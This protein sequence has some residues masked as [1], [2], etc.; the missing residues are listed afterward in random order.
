MRILPIFL[1]LFV[2]LIAIIAVPIAIHAPQH[3]APGLGP[4]LANLGK[5]E[6]TFHN[7]DLQLAGLV[8]NPDR[9][10]K[11]AIV[12]IHGSGTSRRDN[13]WYLAIANLLENAG[14]I[15]LLPD[16]RGSESSDG[17]GR[18]A[19]METLATNTEAALTLLRALYPDLPLGVVGV[20][21]GG[22]VA[23]IVA[24]R[25]PELSFVANLSGSAVPARDQLV[26]EEANTIDNDI[27]APKWF[28]RMIAPVTS[29]NIRKRVQPELWSSL[30]DFN[31]VPYWQ[32]ATMPTFI[33]YGQLDQNDNV[34][35]AASVANLAALDKPNLTVKTYPN[36]GHGFYDYASGELAP[37]FTADLT[38]FANE[39][40]K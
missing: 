13:R 31:S 10:P 15:V 11:S 19:S 16:K 8:F 28:A 37:A 14:H 24:S 23:S 18:T 1:G 22:W 9:T 40:S 4:S 38:S 12:I 30:E 32:R 17:D 36:V 7:D 27:G 35:V 5:D 20:S 29:W 6:V 34:P 21:Q 33:A 39:H 2:I 26:L 25:N 3:R